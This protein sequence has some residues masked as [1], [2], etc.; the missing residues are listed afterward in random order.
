MVRLTVATN[1]I[2]RL[3]VRDNPAV[4]VGLVRTEIPTRLL[5]MLKLAR[6][7]ELVETT[8]PSCRVVDPDAWTAPRFMMVT[9]GIPTVAPAIDVVD[10]AMGV[11][12]GTQAASP[13]QFVDPEP[14]IAPA[15]KSGGTLIGGNPAV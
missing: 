10:C 5:I 7:P 9:P 3:I 15:L 1:G 2:D 14:V 12:S 13:A 4:S 6:L 8:D 11:P